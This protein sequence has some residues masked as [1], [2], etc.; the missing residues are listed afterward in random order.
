MNRVGV[1]RD[2]TNLCTKMGLSRY[3]CIRRS[4]TF[5]SLDTTRLRCNH[6]SLLQHMSVMAAKI[7]TSGASL[8]NRNT[9]KHVERKAARSIYRLS[10]VQTNYPS[11]R[12]CV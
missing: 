4:N 9:K 7:D 10:A 5:E 11:G 6:S 1:R 12:W 3:V 8:S 2:R